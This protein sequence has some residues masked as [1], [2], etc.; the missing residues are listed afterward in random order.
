M[1]CFI[2]LTLQTGINNSFC[3]KL[4]N[5]LIITRTIGVTQNR[6]FSLGAGLVCGTKGLGL[7][8]VSDKLV[9][10][11]VSSKRVSCTSLTNMQY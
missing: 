6:K 10:V 5:N 11:S 7:D 8:L 4:Q 1:Q 2:E 9:N 3:L